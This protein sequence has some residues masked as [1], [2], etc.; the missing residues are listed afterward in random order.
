MNEKVGIARLCRDHFSSESQQAADML[1]P[2]RLHARRHRDHVVKAKL[3]PLMVAEGPEFL[4]N[5]RIRTRIDSTW[6]TSV[7]QWLVS[8][9]K[10]QTVILKGSIPTIAGATCSAVPSSL[11]GSS[12]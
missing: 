12:G 10:P 2:G 1:G 11:S 9:A 6:L 8:S 5:G 7:L 3:V 4:G